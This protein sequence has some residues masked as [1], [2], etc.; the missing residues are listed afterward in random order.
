MI[1]AAYPYTRIGILK[2][3]LGVSYLTA[4]KYLD[5]LVADNL[6]AKVRIGRDSYYVNVSMMSILADTGADSLKIEH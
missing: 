1:Q 6:L 5:I 2:D 4:R 3:R